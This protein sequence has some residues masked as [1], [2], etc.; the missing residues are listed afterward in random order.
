VAVRKK[1]AKRTTRR[2]PARKW[3]ARV[4]QTSDALTL[5]EG[6][7]KHGDPREI[8]LSL[9]RSADS[10]KRRKGTPFQSAMSMLTFYINRAGTGLSA[11]ERKRLDRAKDEL[12]EIYGREEARESRQAT[13]TASRGATRSSRKKSARKSTKKSAKRTK[14]TTKRATKKTAKKRAVMS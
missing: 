9:R 14:R 13:K 1:S 7:F 11:A 5:E 10:S 2:S 6:V 8:A 3:S 12:R 4:T